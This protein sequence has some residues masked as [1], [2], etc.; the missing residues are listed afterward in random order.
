MCFQKPLIM[1]ILNVTPNSFYDG[2]RFDGL[3]KALQRVDE[4]VKEG[5]G[6]VD[7]GGQAGLEAPL[8]SA[9]EELTRVL[10]VVEAVRSTFP[11]LKVS[12]DTSKAA[13]AQKVLEKGVW[14]IND[15]SSGRE[16]PDMMPLIAK[17]DCCF[18]L[19]FNKSSAS[20]AKIEA[21]E[22]EDVSGVIHTFLKN[23]IEMAAIA[24]IDRSRLMVD[25]GLGHYISSQAS[26]SWEVLE[27]LKKLQTFDCPILVSP[28]RKSFT[29]EFEG[30]APSERLPG[31][32]KA[33]R[34]ALK[35]GA[36]VI[37]THDVGET[38]ELITQ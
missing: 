21:L 10:P 30:Q 12:V 24:G 28:S 25:P 37:R 15:T 19:M 18:V 34:L 17:E 27:H 20:T 14:M 26:Y 33:T 35:N 38:I 13:V 5:A 16:D 31:T 1:G 11:A 6:A 9:K 32:L 3:E 2:G 8:I 22:Y 7:I 4:M 36:T 23:G 29:A